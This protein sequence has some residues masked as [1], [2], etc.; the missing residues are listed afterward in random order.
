M[1]AGRATQGVAHRAQTALSKED[2]KAPENKCNQQKMWD[3]FHF[4]V[5]K[6]INM[7]TKIESF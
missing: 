5:M 1:R 7:E 2:G 4:Q 3:I 6:E